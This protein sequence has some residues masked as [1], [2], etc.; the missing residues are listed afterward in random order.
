MIAVASIYVP[1][2]VVTGN[3]FY[4]YFSTIYD[5][6]LVIPVYFIMRRISQT[7][8]RLKKQIQELKKKYLW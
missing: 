5:F 4:F 1:L 3:L 2:G 7:E 6:V 8:Q